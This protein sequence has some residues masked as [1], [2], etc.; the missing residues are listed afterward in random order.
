MLGWS[1]ARHTRGLGAEAVHECRLGG[2]LLD[3]T[4]TATV[5]S[6]LICWAF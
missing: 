6:R 2:Q 3:I 4:L 1:R 5:R